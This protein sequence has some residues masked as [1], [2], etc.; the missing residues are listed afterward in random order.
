MM[1]YVDLSKI[2][3]LIHPTN[4]AWCR[5][6]GPAF[7]VRKGAKDPK[8]IVSWKYNAWGDKYAHDLDD[9][10]PGLIASYL[11]IPAFYPGIVMEGG[12]V[13]FNGNGT[14]LTTTQCLLHENRN[15]R[16]SQHEI[17]EYLCSFYGVDQILWLDEGIEG[18]DTN[19]ISTTLH[20]FSG[21]TV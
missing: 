21:R 8:A 20:V 9:K 18:D 10:I 17:E 16:L 6:H 3:L 11:N 5:D 14:L 2:N 7:L 12:S 1:L 4:D 15:P 13:D 19:G